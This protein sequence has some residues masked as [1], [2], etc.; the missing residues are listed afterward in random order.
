MTPKLVNFHV[1]I[2]GQFSAAVDNG[3][4]MIEVH[5]AGPGAAEIFAVVNLEPDDQ[6][7]ASMAV[8]ISRHAARVSSSS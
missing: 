8:Y 6:S 4:A 1:P 5:N 3:A 2:A 7:S